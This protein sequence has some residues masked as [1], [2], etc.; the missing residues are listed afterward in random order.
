MNKE[1]KIILEHDDVRMVQHEDFMN[2]MTYFVDM[3]FKDENVWRTI[4]TGSFYYCHD[5]Y[6]QLIKVW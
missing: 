2:K 4:R 1:F 6:K 3:Y 5:L